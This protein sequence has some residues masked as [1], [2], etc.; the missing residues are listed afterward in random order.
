MRLPDC[1]SDHQRLKRWEQ[2]HGHE[3]SSPGR[4]PPTDALG[5]A[6][7]TLSTRPK[8]SALFMLSI[9]SAASPRSSNWTKAKPRCFSA[10][11]RARALAANGAMALV[12]CGAREAL[13]SGRLTSVISPK[14]RKAACRIS[15]VTLSSSPPVAWIVGVWQRT[16][17]CSVPRSRAPTYS[18]RLSLTMGALMAGAVQGRLVAQR[19][20]TPDLEAAAYAMYLAITRI[21]GGKYCSL[22]P[23]HT[24]TAC[25]LLFWRREGLECE[26]ATAYAAPKVLRGRV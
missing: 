7:L 26:P 2:V 18:V 24:H 25:V 19:P 6:M 1:R 21:A 5:L 13:S 14:G 22:F 12:A 23:A 17:R 3:Q 16:V 11:Q 20:D 9:A 8:S 4:W 10:V 15:C